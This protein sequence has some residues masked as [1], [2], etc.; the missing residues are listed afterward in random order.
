MYLKS[1]IHK[2]QF[3]I[4][5]FGITDIIIDFLT[6]HYRMSTT[7]H[8]LSLQMSRAFAHDAISSSAPSIPETGKRP[9]G[10]GAPLS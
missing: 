8:G 2:I 4:R 3:A 7:L 6:D 9:L 5:Q 10:S 1:D